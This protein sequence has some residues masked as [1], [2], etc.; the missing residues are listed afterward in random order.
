MKGGQGFNSRACMR[1]GKLP[2]P[3]TRKGLACMCQTPAPWKRPRPSQDGLLLQ[4]PASAKK[5]EGWPAS[6][7][8]QEQWPASAK[9]QEGW[10]RPRPS[11]IRCTVFLM[12]TL[13][14][15]PHIMVGNNLHN[16]GRSGSGLHVQVPTPCQ[17]LR[18]SQIR[19]IA[20]SHVFLNF[21]AIHHC[22]KESP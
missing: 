6:A 20:L 3:N 5:Q 21:F 22:G 18:P 1:P 2:D 15:F 11:Q 12:D 9:K 4:W 19:C 7:K 10:K 8:K 13:I 14:S 17:I 16:Y